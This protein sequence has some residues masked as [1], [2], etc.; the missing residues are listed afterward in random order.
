MYLC[1]ASRR[2]KT[3]FGWATYHTKE[4]D[5]L[6]EKGGCVEVYIVGSVECVLAVHG[7]SVLTVRRR[8]NAEVPRPV[9]I[10]SE[11][12]FSWREVRKNEWEY[13]IS[14]SEA[15]CG[16]ADVAGLG[17]AYYDHVLEPETQERQ[18]GERK[19]PPL[20]MLFAYVKQMVHIRPRRHAL[21][22]DNEQCSIKQRTA[23]KTGK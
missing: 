10:C 14:D 15:R 19:S 8:A 20:L 23:I 3:D 12:V 17:S 9:H 2:I 4:N 11:N 6:E 13:L 1:Y 22:S 5:D 21:R 7:V 16:T 18:V